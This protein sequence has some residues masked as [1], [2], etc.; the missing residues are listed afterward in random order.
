MS[1]YKES[2]PSHNLYPNILQLPELHLVVQPTVR[3]MSTSWTCGAA[4]HHRAHDSGNTPL[5]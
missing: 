5:Y 1:S 3:R 2:L 4:E